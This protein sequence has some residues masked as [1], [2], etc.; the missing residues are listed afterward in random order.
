MK[1]VFVISL[2]GQSVIHFNRVVC[3]LMQFSDFQKYREI[4]KEQGFEFSDQPSNH[5]QIDGLECWWYQ[6]I[7]EG[8]D[9]TILINETS[10]IE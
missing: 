8:I 3:V 2:Y 7:T 9:A 6:C 4:L 1:T 5:R 10:V